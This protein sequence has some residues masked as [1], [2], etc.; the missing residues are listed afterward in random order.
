MHRLKICVVPVYLV[1]LATVSLVGCQK[2]TTARD[3]YEKSFQFVN[4]G[5]TQDAIDL[6]TLAIKKDPSFFE[7]Y[8]NRGT[9]YFFQEKYDLALKDFDKA[10]SLNAN[11]GGSY[12]SRGTVYDR[13][14][15]PGESLAD[16]KAAAR[17]GDKD[18]QDYLKSKG[19]GWQKGQ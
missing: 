7:A 12:A 4:A 5:S 10:I 13:M 18:T 9:M 6:L 3:Y 14:N 15:M 2:E 16:F 19:V 1:L 8:Y 11:H 17:L